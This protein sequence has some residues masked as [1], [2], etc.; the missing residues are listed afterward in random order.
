[1][2]KFITREVISSL[3]SIFIFLFVMFYAINILIPGDFLTPLRLMMSQEEL[4]TLRD[5]LGANDPLYQ[6]YFRWILSVFSGEISPGGF[7]Q[8]NGKDI[9]S[10]IFPTLNILIPSFLLSFN[11]SKIPVLKTKIKK[12]YKNKIISDTFSTFLISIFP[13]ITLFVI[14]GKFE[15]AFQALFTKYNIQKPTKNLIE[16]SDFQFNLTIFVIL[17][18]IILFFTVIIDLFLLVKFNKYKFITLI[19]LILYLSFIDEI[20]LNDAIIQSQ[21]GLLTISIMSTFFI[22]EF[23]LMNNVIVQNISREPHI[24]TARALGYSNSKIFSN[25]IIR[26]TFGPFAT[27]LGLSLPFTI[28]SLVIV[29]ST[30][31]WRGMGSLLYQTIMN[32]DSNAAMG[33]FLLLAILTIFIR[34]SISIF[35]AFVDP[36]IRL[37]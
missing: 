24:L 23:I 27:R 31:N 32:Q 16:Y 1:M 4:D 34:I 5:S 19:F 25:H 6:R 35:Q 26:N 12:L 2:I 10:T 9:L 3:I 36:R 20:L 22:G 13:P 30:T 33:I 8:R 17:L 14:G 18:T 21:D 29:E 11:I 7:M 28:A 37:K 15:N